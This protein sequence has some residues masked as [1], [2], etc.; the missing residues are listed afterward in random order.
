MA[1]GSPN[2][3]QPDRSDLLRI[4]VHA[5]AIQKRRALWRHQQRPLLAFVDDVNFTLGSV[6]DRA[7]ELGLRQTHQVV[8]LEVASI[9][10]IEPEGW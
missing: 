9:G 7:R 3:P 5:I 6:V 8:Y 10:A 1:S 4:H 2:L